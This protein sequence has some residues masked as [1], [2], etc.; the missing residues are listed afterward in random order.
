MK[1]KRKRRITVRCSHSELREWKKLADEQGVSLSRLILDLL[2]LETIKTEPDERVQRGCSVKPMC[3][4]ERLFFR[5]Y[6]KQM[7]QKAGRAGYRRSADAPLK[8]KGA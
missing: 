8:T 6:E 5:P 4:N 2:E 1:L 3:G 7:W